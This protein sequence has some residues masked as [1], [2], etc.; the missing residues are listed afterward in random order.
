MA[1]SGTESVV[2]TPETRVI[3]TWMVEGLTAVS[4]RIWG[5]TSPTSSVSCVS[6]T[7]PTSTSPS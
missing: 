6:S 5:V 4:A 7:E 2:V 3:G 1:P